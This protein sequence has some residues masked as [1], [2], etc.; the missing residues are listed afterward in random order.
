MVV[1]KAGTVGGSGEDEGWGS[2][3]AIAESGDEAT[4]KTTEHEIH[5]LVWHF[6]GRAGFLRKPDMQDAEGIRAFDLFRSEFSAHIFT[7]GGSIAPAHIKIRDVE[8]K[9]LVYTEN[10]AILETAGRTRDYISL[11][12][13]VAAK[14]GIPPEDFM[15]A[16]VRSRNFQEMRENC[17]I[18]ARI[19]GAEDSDLLDV[20]SKNSKNMQMSSAMKELSGRI[21][22][23]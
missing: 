9:K 19:T 3:V 12:M 6:L 23:Q 15:Y 10:K 22:I 1:R 8:P 7:E 18:L 5:H 17:F 2:L 11:C 20:L 16:A 14:K 21:K 13:E 4:R